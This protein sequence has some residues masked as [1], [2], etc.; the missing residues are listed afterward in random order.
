MAGK[1]ARQKEELLVE[2]SVYWLFW[3]VLF[4]LCCCFVLEL[5]SNNL[6]VAIERCLGTKMFAEFH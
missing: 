5:Q 4:C 2:I 6:S 1:P 3:R